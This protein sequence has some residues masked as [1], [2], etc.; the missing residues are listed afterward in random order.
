MKA[1]LASIVAFYQARSLVLGIISEVVDGRYHIVSDTEDYGW[2]TA[3]RFVLISK[4]QYPL[5]EYPDCLTSFSNSLKAEIEHLSKLDYSFLVSEQPITEIAKQM[6]L[7]A[8]H[9]VFALYSY[10]KAHPEQFSFKKEQF[11]K[12]TPEELEAYKAELATEQQ[13][14][15]FFADISAL[16]EGKTVGNDTLNTLY[17]ELSEVVLEN[18]HRDLQRYL[19]DAIPNLGTEEA[20]VRLRK[21]CGEL[22]DS[23]D[24]AISESGIPVGFSPLIMSENLQQVDWNRAGVTAFSIDD[25]D[26]RDYDDALSLQRNAEGWVLG[27]HMSAVAACIPQSSALFGEALRRS[28][29]LYTANTIVPL[30]PPKLSEQ[31]LSLV[32]GSEK[33]VISLYVSLDTE[34]N[35]TSRSFQTELL[36]IEHNYSYRQ[37]DKSITSEP[38]ATLQRISACLQMRR[39]SASGGEKQ[40]FYYYL[41]EYD[42]ILGLKRVDNLSPARNIIEEL[43]IEYNSSFAAFA[44]QRGCP[45]IFRNI[46]VFANPN[47]ET[48]ASQ[49]YLSTAAD[50]HPGIGASQYLHATSPIRRVVDLLNQYQMLT[51]LEGRVHPCSANELEG[52][53]VGIEK[54]LLLL[55]EVGHRSQRYWLLKYLEQSRLHEPLD[56]C[57][58]GETQGKLRIELL[59]WG[60]QVLAKCDVYP[61]Q[62]TFKLVIYRI[63]WESWSLEAD[64]L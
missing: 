47:G 27:I 35:V 9:E 20:V 19:R 10:L 56:A 15:T 61:S 43:M 6:G 11:R 59:P 49:A 17:K 25:E 23:I 50:F 55:R 12:K 37:V 51:L 60:F 5:D 48:P 3:A 57:L 7:T 33:P 54:R 38:F 22:D 36:P 28:S 30:F 8:D 32:A 64:V 18:K 40:R 29:S 14:S 13:R 63:D 24:P 53:I 44:V 39:Q 4:S 2:F 62:D 41:K 26:T 21:L 16:L 45:M 31:E 52:Y 34:L 46:T 42:G 58:L 1:Q